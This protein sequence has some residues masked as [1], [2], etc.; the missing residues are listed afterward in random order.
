MEERK[1][2]VTLGET[3][4]LYNSAVAFATLASGQQ[5]M[6]TVTPLEAMKDKAEY[7]GVKNEGEKNEHAFCIP[8]HKEAQINASGDYSKPRTLFGGKVRLL[9]K[10]EVYPEKTGNQSAAKILW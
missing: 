9:M 6:L 1:I 3:E 2:V 5:V 10:L 8:Q 7:S 4:E